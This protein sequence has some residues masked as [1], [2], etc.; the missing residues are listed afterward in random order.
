MA[1]VSFSFAGAQ[2]TLHRTDEASWFKSELLR[3]YPQ[4]PTVAD[5]RFAVARSEISAGSFNAARTELGALIASYPQATVRPF[6][7]ALLEQISGSKE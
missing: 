2:A 6:A 3:R 7:D 1:R 4:N 5:L